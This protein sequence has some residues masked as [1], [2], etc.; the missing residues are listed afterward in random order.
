VVV[1][2]GNGIGKAV[3][4]TLGKE[5]AHIV[6]ADLSLDAA[7]ATANELTKIHGVGIGVAG[8][9]ISGCGPAIAVQVDVTDRGSVKAMFDEVTLAYGGFDHIVVT[10]GVFIAPDRTGHVTDEQFKKTF[11]VN[12]LGS[13]LIGDEAGK[14]FNEQGLKGTIV[15]TT[16]V[17]AVVAKKG[18]VAYDTSKAAANHL[19][20][21]LA[22]ELSPHVRVNGVAPATVV[23]G[24]T[25]FPRD[26]VIASLVKYNISFEETEDSE[27]LRNRLANF[28]A[29]RTLTKAPITP[30]DQANAVLF[31]MSN[32]SAKIT[33]Q[34]L[35][36]DG[37]LPEAFVR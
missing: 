5:G 12:V 27:S 36:V 34:V 19:L 18:S 11:E 32:R 37:G 31:L 9:G 8:T 26:R 1:G 22:V 7:Q 29:Q 28:Y 16:S 33:G 35:Q 4:H 20:R 25:M 3:A 14:I 10:A 30:E 2:A 6:C 15:L 23:S 13:Y 24:S 17:N 21:E